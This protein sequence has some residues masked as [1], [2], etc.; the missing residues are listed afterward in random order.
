M[1]THHIDHELIR[2]TRIER[3]MTQQEVA[4]LAELAVHTYN[5]IECGRQ[6]PRIPNLRR[7]A[8]A[9]GL[10]APELIKL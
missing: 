7:I 9:L 10:S 5:R 3:C 6:T 2:K 1:V 8:A 4:D